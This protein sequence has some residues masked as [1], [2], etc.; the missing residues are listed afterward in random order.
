MGKKKMSLMTHQLKILAQT[1]Y[2]DCVAYFADMGL[3]KTFIGSEK[4]NQINNNTNL[5]LCQKSKVT[6][7][8][9]HFKD[10]YEEYT[11]I[12]C[13]KEK[14]LL[15]INKITNKKVLIINYDLIF[16]REFFL[17]LK[18]FTLLLDESSIIQN[19]KSK[20]AKFILKLNPKNVIL[21]SGTP[22]SGKYENLYSQCKLLGWNITKEL[23][24]KQYVNYKS[25]DV[26]GYIYKVVD[27]N[28]P[29]KNV[30]RLK[31]KL[32]EHGAV[33]L[34]TE[35]CFDLP[36]QNFVRINIKKTKDY[37]KFLKDSIVKVNKDVLVGD[38]NLV[39][40]MYLRKLCGEYNKEKLQAF[41]D[42]ISSTQDRLLVFY[43]FNNELE[44]LKNIAI[45]LEKPISEFNGEV[46]N[47]SNYENEENSVTFIQ[48]QAGSMGL[49]LQKANKIIY[50]TLTETSE[51][52]EQSK[53]RI[54]RI[55]QEKT[56]FYYLLICENSIEESIL[57]SL[58]IKKDF[59]D[60]LFK[61]SK[62]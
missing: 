1:K 4:V 57:K 38:T 39:K 47:L 35:E 14:N 3:G 29:Y 49:N 37:E 13:T 45:K 33:F 56:C 2:S 12:D 44:I 19:E 7:W 51:L 31:Q 36:K 50:F 21:L 41:E 28:N 34:K 27:K 52:F 40:R 15:E 60:D 22:V 5:I 16:R 32:R 24:D 59:T 10:Y 9:N 62:E 54:H 46:K 26:G 11:V 58:E 43:N 17:T 53:K 8:Y 30:E 20:R 48:Y 23:Y 25:I 55:G 61:F 6:D 42:L 18:D